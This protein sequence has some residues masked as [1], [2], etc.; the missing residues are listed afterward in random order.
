MEEEDMSALLLMAT[1]SR[2]IARQPRGNFTKHI[3]SLLPQ[4]RKMR[5]ARIRYHARSLAARRQNL[6]ILTSLKG[7]NALIGCA[8]Q[9]EQWSGHVLGMHDGG[10]RQKCAGIFVWPASIVVDLLQVAGPH[11]AEPV[12]NARTLNGSF[13]A[14][15]LSN[16]PRGHKTAR[17]PAKYRKPIRIRPALRDGK[18]GGAVYVA[19]GAISKVLVDGV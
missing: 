1:L 12:G 14:V 19:I 17:A 16:R 6:E 7:R 11:K 3:L 18:V 13:V 4:C 5:R 8:M 9:N 15:R 2:V 10:E